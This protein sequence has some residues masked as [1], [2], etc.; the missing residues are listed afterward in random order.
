MSAGLWPWCGA[1]RLRPNRPSRRSYAQRSDLPDPPRRSPPRLPRGGRPRHSRTS[2]SRIGRTPGLQG[3]RPRPGSPEGSWRWPPARRPRNE[4]RSA[5]LRLSTPGL[6]ER[7]EPAAR[8]WAPS[9]LTVPQRPRPR[10]RVSCRLRRHSQGGT[11]SRSAQSPRCS[12]RASSLQG[13]EARVRRVPTKPPRVPGT[14]Q[15]LVEVAPIGQRDVPD[16]PPVAIQLPDGHDDGLPERRGRP[17]TASPACRRPGPVSGASIPCKRMT[18]GRPSW[19]TVSVSPSVMPTTRPWNSRASTAPTSPRARRKA[20]PARTIPCTGRETAGAPPVSRWGRA[21]SGGRQRSTPQSNPGHGSTQGWPRPRSPG[22]WRG[23]RSRSR[24]ATVADRRRPPVEQPEHR[25]PLAPVDDVDPDGEDLAV[26]GGADLGSRAAPRRPGWSSARRAWAT[27]LARRRWSASARARAPGS[28]QPG[29]DK[30][31]GLAP[32]PPRG[33]RGSPRAR[34]AR[35][36][37]CWRFRSSSGSRQVSRAR[38]W[39]RWTRSPSRTSS[40]RAGSVRWAMKS[41]VTSSNSAAGGGAAGAGAGGRLRRPD[42][43]DQHEPR[44]DEQAPE[45]RAPPGRAGGRSGARAR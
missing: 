39:P 20:S 12:E 9:W 32:S 5:H 37:P 8:H 4:Q 33:A 26:D 40:S 28:R 27:A 44:Q 41:S 13:R 36:G 22:A 15:L 18:V 10:R 16:G 42:R 11:G 14:D 38:S 7:S 3:Q 19:R 17:Q 6:A 45:L 21:A 25:R 24:H 34:R 23:G 1:H 43:L 31:P 35:P 2:R 30:R 29:G